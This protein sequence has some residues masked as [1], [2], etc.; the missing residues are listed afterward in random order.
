MC[1]LPLLASDSISVECIPTPGL[2]VHGLTRVW[3]GPR[4]AQGS[5]T[6]GLTVIRMSRPGARCRHCCWS[7]SPGRSPNPPCVSP[8]NGLSMVS[9]VGLFRQPGPRVGEQGVEPAARIGHRPTVKLGLHLRYPPTRTRR[10][11]LVGWGV[12]IRWRVFRHYSLQSLLDTTAVLRH[13]TGSPG[14][15]LLRRL[16]PTPGRSADGVPSPTDHAGYV[17]PGRPGV[18]PVFTC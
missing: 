11:V 12:T 6:P 1:T 10:I 17:A 13:V 4:S 3:R 14:L 7:V 18:V 16:R 8:R 9:A 2:R 5:L 15:G